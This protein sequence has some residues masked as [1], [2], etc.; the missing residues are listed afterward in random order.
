LHNVLD[1]SEVRKMD[2]ARPR[3]DAKDSIAGTALERLRDRESVRRLALVHRLILEETRHP[4]SSRLMTIWEQLARDKA[5]YVWDQILTFADKIT[6]GVAEENSAAD[7]R[8][9]S[10]GAQDNA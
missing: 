2:Y 10:T 5:L 3:S 4:D 9:D 1:V 7:V 8:P 6:R